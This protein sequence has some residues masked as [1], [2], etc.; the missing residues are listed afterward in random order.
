[1][2]V[3]HVLINFY[4]IKLLILTENSVEVI[5]NFYLVFINIFSAYYMI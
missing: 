3:T 1:M 5:E 4:S 2:T